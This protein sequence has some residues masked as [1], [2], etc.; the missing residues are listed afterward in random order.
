MRIRR[1]FYVYLL[2]IYPVYVTII[3]SSNRLLSQSNRL[4]A[5]NVRHGNHGNNRDFYLKRRRLDI[6]LPSRRSKETF[7]KSLKCTSN[8]LS[9]QIKPLI[10][11]YFVVI[12]LPTH[13]RS[14]YGVS[15]QETRCS[16]VQNR[17][18]AGAISSRW[19]SAERAR[20]SVRE[21]M[22]WLSIR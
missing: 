2:G 16:C 17:V 11:T 15:C 9:A 7:I 21:T 4:Y 12:S 6:A 14:P 19:L 1:L 5:H 20:S 18:T 3:R 8:R 10:C 13:N 22:R